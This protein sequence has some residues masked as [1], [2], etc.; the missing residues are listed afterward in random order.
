MRIDINNKMNQ[1]DLIKDT[2]SKFLNKYNK[3]RCVNTAFKVS[4][5]AAVQHNK[6]YSSHA[7][8]KDKEDIRDEWGKELIRLGEKFHENISIEEY[9]LFVV[10]LKDH[11]NL[12]FGKLFDSK[13][14]HGSMFRISHSQKS[15]SVFVKHLWC[16]DV[17]SEPNICPV[18]RIILRKTEAKKN[19]D[20]SWGYVNSIEEH[21]R[22]FK[23][24]QK[25]AKLKQLRVAVWELL[26][27]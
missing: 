3:N 9:Q 21:E 12:K 20:I 10:K 16:M 13:S 7:S 6:I 24:I 19:N 27:F 17:I 14:K 2:K 18:D 11:M 8:I 5:K 25:Q 22:K 1:T 26:S 4:I 15:I 23:Y